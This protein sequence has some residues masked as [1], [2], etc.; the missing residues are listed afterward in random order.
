MA[1]VLV[2]DPVHDA[3]LAILREAPGVEYVHLPEP[4]EPDIVHHMAD[5]DALILRG[6]RLPD[7]IFEQASRLRLVSRH[8]VGCD[9]VDFALMQKM[10]VTVAVAADSNYV[11]VAEHA[12]AL[13]LAALKRLP[14]ADRAVREANWSLRDHLG[15]R[16]LQGSRVLVVGFGRIGRAFATRIEAFGAYCLVYDP[17]LVADQ[18]P[19]PSQT[20]VATLEEGL[21]EADIVSLHLPNTE[22]S[23]NLLDAAR[24]QHMR[25]GSILVNTARGGIVNEGALLESLDKRRPAI[26]ATDVL[27]TEPPLPGDPLLSRPDVIFTPHSAAMTDAAARRMSERAAQNAVDFLSGALS[28]EMIAFQPRGDGA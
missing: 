1:K 10:K 24:L 14:D 17:F 15:A 3:G 27:A 19:T 5:A 25:E 11:S 8:G 2:L 4:A 12:M 28:A 22:Q 21:A 16:E 7:S 9:N 23:V 13:T 18:T 6:R 26:Y 20:P